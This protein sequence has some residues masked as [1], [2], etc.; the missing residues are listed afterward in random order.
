MTASVTI[1]TGTRTNVLLVP[2][3]AVKVGTRGI[4]VN[5]LTTEGRASQR[6]ERSGCKPAPA[7]A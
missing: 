7:T 4:T 5:V 2:S 1:A 3:E 6:R